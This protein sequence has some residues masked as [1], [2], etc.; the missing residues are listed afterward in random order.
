[1]KR[2][3]T[4]LFYAYL[5]MIGSFLVILLNI[6]LVTFIMSHVQILSLFIFAYV[7]L[8]FILYIINIGDDQM[9]LEDILYGDY[10]KRHSTK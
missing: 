8:S 9:D 4:A 1:M 2:L 10:E 5:V 7:L 3:F 6:A